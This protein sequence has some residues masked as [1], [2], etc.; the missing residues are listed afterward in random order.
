MILFLDIDGVLNA[1]E[2]LPSGYCGICREQVELLNTMLDELPDL[3]IVV[4]SAWRY[5]ILRGDMTIKGFEYLLL[6]QGV[7]CGNR[8]IG[9]T[10]ADGEVCDEP[11]H[12]ATELWKVIGLKIRALQIAKYIRDNNVK[13]FAVLDD[14]PLEVDNLVQTDWQKGITKSDIKQAV[15]ILLSQ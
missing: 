4:S 5:L 12:F 1:H 7:R 13:V 9:H 8:V 2:K 11:D 10:V 15:K 14:L 3:K 6:V